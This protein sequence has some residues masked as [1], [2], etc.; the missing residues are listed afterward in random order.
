[1]L[2][3]VD[4]QEA[5]NSRH[6]VNQ[7]NQRAYSLWFVSTRKFENQGNLYGALIN[8]KTMFGFSMFPQ[9]LA[10]ITGDND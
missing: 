2:G 9:H 5:A 6:N 4:V 8:E 3:P 1:M 10:M 7:A